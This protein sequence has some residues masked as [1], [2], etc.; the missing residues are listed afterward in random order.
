MP[1]QSG[2]SSVVS[3][4]SRSRTNNGHT[5]L[6]HNVAQWSNR[7]KLTSRKCSIVMEESDAWS[8]RCLHSLLASASPTW[9]RRS[10]S[11]ESSN[12]A[13]REQD[14]FSKDES[15]WPFRLRWLV[16]QSRGLLQG[17]TIGS[18]G[19][20]VHPN[21]RVGLMI[22]SRHSASRHAQ[23]EVV[24]SFQHNPA[25]TWGYLRLCPRELTMS[26]GDVV[27]S[28]SYGCKRSV[29]EIRNRK[30]DLYWLWEGRLIFHLHLRLT[31]S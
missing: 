8:F 15:P 18:W 13:C 28:C 12:S 19:Q 6:L 16:Q 14:N 10:L 1:I 11:L 5:S 2:E 20:E 29:N 26:I 9:A 4:S 25:D 30:N 23:R 27:S 24:L 21:F 22:C 17:Q 7:F 31:V 3:C